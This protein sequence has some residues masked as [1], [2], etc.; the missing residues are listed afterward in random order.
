[1]RRSCVACQ[2]FFPSPNILRRMPLSNGGDFTTTIFIAG[3]PF[4]MVCCQYMQTAEN[5]HGG[6]RY[7]KEEHRASD[8]LLKKTHRAVYRAF[9]NP[10]CGKA[11]PYPSLYC[12]QRPRCAN[13]DTFS[14]RSA[15][16]VGICFGFLY[17]IVGFNARYHVLSRKRNRCVGITC[18]PL[19]RSRSLESTCHR[20]NLQH[21]QT[22]RHHRW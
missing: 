20:S 2:L 3:T 13:I 6:Q 7:K 19:R 4:G 18:V 14:G 15:N 10:A 21:R 12:S 9:R 16:H 11:V 5:C 8:V 22:H 1:M 17:S